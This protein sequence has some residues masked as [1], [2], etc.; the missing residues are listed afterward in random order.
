MSDLEKITLKN[1]IKIKILKNYK[2]Y[3]LKIDLN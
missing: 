3:V 1:Q 2:I